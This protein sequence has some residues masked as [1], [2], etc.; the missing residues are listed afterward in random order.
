MSA[1][2]INRTPKDIFTQKIR[3]W[4]DQFAHSLQSTDIKEFIQELVIE[5]F[6]NYI[7]KRT[8]PYMIIAFC[9]FGAVFLFVI[10]TFV[11]LL[12][13]RP[14]MLQCPACKTLVRTG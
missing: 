10:L 12:F 8:F 13:R 1:T 9:L 3:I 14:D 5:P 11:L 2:Q 6:M 7:L 4:V